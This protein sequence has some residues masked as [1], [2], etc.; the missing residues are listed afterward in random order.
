MKIPAPYYIPE[1]LKTGHSGLLVCEINLSKLLSALPG[2]RKLLLGW[3]YIFRRSEDLKLR[4]SETMH[5]DYF[6]DISSALA[7]AVK[8]PQRQLLLFRR[9]EDLKLRP[10]QTIYRDYLRKS[11]QRSLAQSK[12]LSAGSYSLEGRRTSNSGLLKQYIGII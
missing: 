8:V 9:S 7:G 1:G 3:L 4:P 5:L 2:A 12:L 11:L 10:S 6:P